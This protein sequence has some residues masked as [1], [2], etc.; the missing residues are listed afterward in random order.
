MEHVRIETN[1]LFRIKWD[2]E[3]RKY[4]KKRV[5]KNR[6][7]TVMREICRLG[8]GVTLRNIFQMV[9]SYPFLKKFI[10]QYSWC[11]DIDAFHQQAYLPTSVENDKEPVVKLAI[12]RF[13]IDHEISISSD[14]LGYGPSDEQGKFIRYSLSMTPM[15]KFAHLPIVLD[16]NIEIQKKWKIGTPVTHEVLRKG[17]AHYSLLEVLDA[18]YWDISFYGG[19]EETEALKCKMT[20]DME[21]YRRGELETFPIDELLQKIEGEKC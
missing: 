9:D 12:E 19:P 10:S 7:F 3:R 6:I 2:S 1:G 8:K 5:R 16:A 13:P 21:A 14:F 4:F 17:K 20:A 11:R 18:I 15:N